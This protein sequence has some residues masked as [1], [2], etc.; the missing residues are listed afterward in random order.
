MSHM[1]VKCMY[2]KYIAGNSVIVSIPKELGLGYE[3]LVCDVPVSNL[4]SVL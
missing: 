2:V 4:L 1:C 3:I